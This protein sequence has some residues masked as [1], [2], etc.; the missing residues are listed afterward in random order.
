MA[1]YGLKT[2]PKMLRVRMHTLLGFSRNNYVGMTRI[3]RPHLGY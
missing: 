2:A 1:S 3:V